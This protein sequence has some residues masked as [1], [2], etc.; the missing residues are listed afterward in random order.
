MLYD[1]ADRDLADLFSSY[2]ANF[3]ATGD[4]NGEGLPRWEASTD[5]TRLME[6]G[7]SIGMVDDRFL[8]IDRVLDKMQGFS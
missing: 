5:G 3:A 8:A 1:S 6:L 7:S 2:F 4:P